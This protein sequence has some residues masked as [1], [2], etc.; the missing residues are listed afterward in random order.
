MELYATGMFFRGNTEKDRAYDCCIHGEVVFT[1]EGKRLSDDTEWCVSA[2]AYRFLH[3]LFKNHF[4]GGEEFLIP[5]C[6]H[7]M[8]PAE[9]KQSVRIFGCSNGL[10]FNIIH[11]GERITVVT[12]DNTA[13]SVTFAEYKQAVVTFAQQVMDFYRSHPPRKFEDEWEK[14]GYGA[15]VTEWYSL[16]DKA[17]SMTGEPPKIIP[18]TFEDYDICGE[19]EITHICEAGISLNPFGFI[20]FRECAYNFQQTEGGL[21]RCVGE[22]DAADLSFT[23]YTSPKPIE[24]KF[25]EK[26]RLLERITT[27][28]TLSRFHKLQKQIEMC[29][30]TTQDMT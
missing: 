2:S 1:V 20:N 23:F 16:Y 3:T 7:M 9:D 15:F 29:G 24:I 14:D 18:I 19:E 12:A 17:G 28:N 8:I 6:G 4:M 21:G 5:C 22:R 11:E 10:D 30:Y 25:V 26:N 27:K 13:Y